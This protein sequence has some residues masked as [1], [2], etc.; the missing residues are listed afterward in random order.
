MTL[1]MKV[2]FPQRV[3]CPNRHTHLGVPFLC[4]KFMFR[5]TSTGAHVLVFKHVKTGLRPVKVRHKSD[6]AGTEVSTGQ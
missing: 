6:C 1:A 4:G 2:C 5:R 3:N